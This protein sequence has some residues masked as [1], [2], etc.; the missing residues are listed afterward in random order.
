MTEPMD[1]EQGIDRQRGSESDKRG[2]WLRPCGVVACHECAD[3]MGQ[4][5]IEG[6][7]SLLEDGKIE[8]R[9]THDGASGS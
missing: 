2:D 3:S 1:R 4:G 9:K 6:E 7:Q 5:I 8:R